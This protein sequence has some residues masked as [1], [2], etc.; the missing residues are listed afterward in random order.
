MSGTNSNNF[1]K[2]FIKLVDIKQSEVKN[3]LIVSI[4]LEIFFILIAFYDNFQIFETDLNGLFLGIISGLVSLIGIAIAGVT[5]VM[6]LFTSKQ[7]RLIDEL[8]QGAYESLLLD[9]KW[10]ALLATSEAAIFLALIFTI[11]LPTALVP[12]IPFYAIVFMLV[13]GVFYLLFYGCALIGNC[14]DFS[15]LKCTLDLIDSQTK[16]I[17]VSAN[18]LK[19]DFLISKLCK[20]DIDLA[21]SFYNELIDIVGESD[22]SNKDDIVKY[23]KERHLHKK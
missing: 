2:Y 11:K 22:L 23:L 3:S 16:S 21:N 19:L 4:L 5:I 8:K 15:K 9:F 10:F 14:I 17:P 6:T 20:K 7:I 13:Y 1:F 12:Q 18:E